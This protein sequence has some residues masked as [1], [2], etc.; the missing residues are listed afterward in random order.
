MPDGSPIH[1]QRIS[2]WF[3]QHTRAAGLPRIRLHDVRHSY[4]TAALA[5]G[6]PPKVISQRLGHATIAITMDTYS[7][8]IPGLDEQAAET[9]ARLILGD[10]EA[11][12]DLSANK[13]LATGQ[14]TD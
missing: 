2:A 12:A 5:A 1:P 4:A 8:V 7:H 10:G 13:P 3:L 6:V 14:R 9:V 11:I